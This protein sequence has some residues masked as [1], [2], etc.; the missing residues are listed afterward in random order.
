LKPVIHGYE[1]KAGVLQK[2]ITG[3][4]AGIAAMEKNIREATATIRGLER[5]VTSVQPT[6]DAINAI[7]TSY[8]FTGFTLAASNQEGYYRV[9]RSDGADATKTLS[10]GE[11]TFLT[12]LYFYHL[13]GGS[14]TASGAT[15]PRVVVIDDPISSLDSDVLYVVSSLVRDILENVRQGVGLVR[16]AFVLT[17]NI[18][19]HKE[20]TF[21]RARSGNDAM[22]HES[23]WTVSKPDGYSILTSYRQ[24]PV[25][26]SYEMLWREVRSDARSEFSIQNTLRR[27]LENYFRILGGIDP[28]SV[29]T[30]FDGKDRV[31]CQSLF[32]WINDGSHYAVDDLYISR[33]GITVERYLEVF[34]R[35]F[36]TL[37]HQAHYDMMMGPRPPAELESPPR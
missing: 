14:D 23:F 11:R 21:Q 26:T 35:I 19:F 17:H 3:L 30:K 29:V 8:G 34:R 2:A 22:K 13:L 33:D 12:F 15:D 1:T 25:R 7:L 28:E 36:V 18:Y 10:E 32:R 27:I 5:R 9:V 24:N 20:V 31:V 16:Q 6:I 4:E 37:G